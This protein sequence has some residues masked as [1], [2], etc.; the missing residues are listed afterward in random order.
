MERKATRK[1]IL[2]YALKAY[3]TEPDYP[4]AEDNTSAVLRRGE[5]KKWYGLIMTIPWQT[6]GVPKAG[7]TDILNLKLDPELILLLLEEKG[8][9]P[10][11]H[12]N[13]THWL[14]LLLDGSLSLAEVSRWL[15]LSYHLAAKRKS[16]PA[17]IPEEA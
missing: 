1:T 4:W 6:L 17:P 5:D 10:A 15:D 8:Y 9:F 13:K 14:T 2:A 11:Y 12:M 7:V 16:R 3:G